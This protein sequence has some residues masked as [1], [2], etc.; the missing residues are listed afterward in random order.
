MTRVLVAEK[1]LV[2]L[3]YIARDTRK[4]TI[5]TPLFFFRVPDRGGILKPSKLYS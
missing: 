5:D 4:K 2:G 3:S 1:A